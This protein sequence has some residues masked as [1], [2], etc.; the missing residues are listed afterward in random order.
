VTALFFAPLEYGN[1]PPQRNNRRVAPAAGLLCDGQTKSCYAK[2]MT[3]V[4]KLAKPIALKDGRT[5]ATLGDARA[6][7]QSLSERRQRNELWLYVGALM[8]EAAVQRRATTEALAQL[9]RAL[10][11]EGLI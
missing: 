4:R 7:M 10:K 3:W 2:P 9:N 6:V 1:A 11:A 8:L 5:I